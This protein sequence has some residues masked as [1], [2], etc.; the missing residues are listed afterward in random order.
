MVNNNEIAAKY[1]D[2]WLGHPKNLKLACIVHRDRAKKAECDI[3][4]PW[5]E[6]VYSGGHLYLPSLSAW[7][8]TGPP[9]NPTDLTAMS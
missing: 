3:P 2:R 4:E 1:R 7:K 8:I 5:K 6:A 9:Y